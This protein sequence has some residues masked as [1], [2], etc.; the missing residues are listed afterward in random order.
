MVKVSTEEGVPQK[1]K[2]RNKHC[3]RLALELKAEFI[4]N[5]N[6]C[7]KRKLIL[8]GSG[9]EFMG[10][11]FPKATPI[12]CH[13]L[14]YYHHTDL[15]M[16]DL[17]NLLDDI[18]NDDGSNVDDDYDD[19]QN[20]PVADGVPARSG[21]PSALAAAAARRRQLGGNDALGAGDEERDYRA[22]ARFGGGGYDEEGDDGDDDDDEDDD[23]DDDGDGRNYNPDYETLKAL[24]TSEMACPEL[25]PHD[26]ETVL[27]IVE[28]LSGKEEVIDELLQRS[29]RQ[30]QQNQSREATGELASL[31]AQIT[32][33]DSDRTRF[34][35]VDLARTRMAKIENH[36]LHNRTLVDRMTEEEV[37]EHH[38]RDV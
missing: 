20:L 33:M 17:D 9:V 38:P 14:N 8:G 32:K 18:N 25:L 1:A 23:D 4:F 7:E 24:W 13:T 29:R 26:A 34:M 5:S 22:A 6:P 19:H 31:M 11:P 21:V 2:E 28:E 36:A 15:T 10:A 35:L 3:S 16:A 12:T 37:R 27:Q 30:G